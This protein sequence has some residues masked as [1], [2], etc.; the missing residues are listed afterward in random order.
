MEEGDHSVIIS[1]TLENIFI[2][3][4]EELDGGPDISFELIFWKESYTKHGDNSNI[5]T[6]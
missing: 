1:S 2:C 3:I 6:R 4:I 5:K